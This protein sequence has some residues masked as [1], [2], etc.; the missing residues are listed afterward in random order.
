MRG[1]VSYIKKY[2]GQSCTAIPIQLVRWKKIRLGEREVN[3]GKCT[4]YLGHKS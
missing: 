1:Y 4:K 2:G 3:E